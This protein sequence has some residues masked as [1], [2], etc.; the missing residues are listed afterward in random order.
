MSDTKII[1]YGTNIYTAPNGIVRRY[2]RHGNMRLVKEL[3]FHAQTVCR[4]QISEQ[5]IATLLN[6][7][8]K[9]FSNG[10]AYFLEDELIGFI[11]WTIKYL[12]KKMMRESTHQI[13]VLKIVLRGSYILIWYVQKKLALP[14]DIKCLMMLKIIVLKM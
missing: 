8:K 7:D 4:N 11:V 14:L 9:N 6:P 1:N 5:Y 10:Y 13:L 2:I 3:F 12:E